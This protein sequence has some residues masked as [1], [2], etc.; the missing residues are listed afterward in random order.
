MT[1]TPGKT[2]K[3]SPEL[4]RRIVAAVMG[5]ERRAARGAAEIKHEVIPFRP[6]PPYPR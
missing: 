4:R 1:K 5:R 6:R 3:L 2:D